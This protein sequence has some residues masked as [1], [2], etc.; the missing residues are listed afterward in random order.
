M[1]IYQ[2]IA[3]YRLIP[4]ITIGDPEKALPLADALTEGGLPLA[5]VT[6]RTDAAA[7][8]IRTLVRERPGFLV[9]AGTILT[10]E[11]LN[12][13][14]DLGA[15][16]GVSPGFSAAVVQTA[17]RRDFPF[18]PGVMTPTEV[19]AAVDAGARVL[20]FFP[21]ET[22]GGPAMLKNISTPFAHLGI[23][24]IPTGGISA[25]GVKSYLELPQVLAVGG[26]WIAPEKDIE[27]GDWDA[28]RANCK[29][30]PPG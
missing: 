19:A 12:K 14:A 1:E 8:V 21:A 5:E 30:I 16:F 22:A 3:R 29:R 17:L 25:A 10:V 26:S 28:V 7:T 18:A 9:G 23:R 6:F 15:K 27:S 24:Y 20:K 2:Q 13:A 4:V 11:Q